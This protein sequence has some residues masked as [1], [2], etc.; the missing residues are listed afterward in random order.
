[1]VQIYAR[2]ICTFLSF[3]QI[4]VTFTCTLGENKPNQYRKVNSIFNLSFHFANSYRKL[5][6]T[7]DTM[8]NVSPRSI[9]FIHFIYWKY[10]LSFFYQDLTSMLAMFSDDI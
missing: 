2:Q 3:P 5:S 6:H 4:Y 10:V 8:K 7:S 1:M 9:Y